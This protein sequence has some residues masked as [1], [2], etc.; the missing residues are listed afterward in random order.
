MPLEIPTT[1]QTLPGE[2]VRI[3]EIVSGVYL[4]VEGYRH[5]GGGL[6]WTEFS[7]T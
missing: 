4:V 2:V 1:S 5:P 7:A 3:T 6:F